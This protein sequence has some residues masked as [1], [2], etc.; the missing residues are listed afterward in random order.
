MPAQLRL[1]GQLLVE[2]RKDRVID[3]PC[4]LAE[5]RFVDGS[6]KPSVDQP[7]CLAERFFPGL[8]D[9]V[10]GVGD[11]VVP[12]GAVRRL[13]AAISEFLGGDDDGAV[14]VLFLGRR[15][16]ILG[17]GHGLVAFKRG[18]AVAGL[19]SASWQM[20]FR[21]GLGHCSAQRGLTFQKD[22]TINASIST[23]Q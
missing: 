19:S 7:S 8:L 13:P 3:D 1:P 21:Q 17:H 22:Q 2:T 16:W 15:H 11:V 12:L 18:R 4:G 9:R 23:L 6:T 14:L 20:T 5:D 10:P